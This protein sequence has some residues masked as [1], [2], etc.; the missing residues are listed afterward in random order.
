MTT[1]LSRGY[2]R[3]REKGVGIEPGA[4]P[5]RGRGP[6]FGNPL[7][8]VGGAVKA[9][10]RAIKPD[11]GEARIAKLKPQIAEKKAQVAGARALKRR[12]GRA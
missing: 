4:H 6:K 1:G 3:A 2:K 10:M 11:S 7:K 5:E 9:A 12:M 8:Q